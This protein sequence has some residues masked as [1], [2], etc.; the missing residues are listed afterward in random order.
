[1]NSLISDAMIMDMM[2]GVGHVCSVDEL[3]LMCL[4]DNLPQQ[5][6]YALRNR[7][8]ADFLIF[9]SSKYLMLKILTHT[10]P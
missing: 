7:P 3:I 5:D 1:M 9:F 2:I 10:S 6:P 8:S 4:I